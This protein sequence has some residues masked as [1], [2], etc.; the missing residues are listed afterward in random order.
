MPSI[1]PYN[2]RFPVIPLSP[3]D[4]QNLT[5]RNIFYFW[6]PL[7]ATWLMM[8]VEGP[9]LAAV[10]ARLTDPKYNLAAYGV[11][12]S[13]ALIVEA[14]I[15]MIMSASTALVKDRQSYFKL[16]NYT[17]TLN[18]LI[19]AGML[20]GLIPPLFRFVA[21]T[22]I[23]LPKP[24]SELTYGA[25][26]LLIPWPGAIG[27]R[28]FY[29]GVLI[30][31]N[32][33]RLVAVGTVIRLGTMAMTAL[34]LYFMTDIPGAWVGA[35]SLS[36]GVSA[37]ALASKLMAGYNIRK[38][39]LTERADLSP[40]TYRGITV[41]YWPLALTSILSLGVQPMVTF[42]MGHSRYPVESLAVLPVV[43]G[44]VFVFRSMG[45]S[46]QEVGIA[47]MGSNGKGYRPLRRFALI[48][49]SASALG[50]ALVVYTPLNH[51]W[52]HTVSGLSEQLTDFALIPARILV[53]MPALS[54]LISWQRGVLVHGGKTGPISWATAAEVTGIILTLLLATRYLDMVGAT[55]AAIG[56]IIGRLAANTWLTPPVVRIRHRM[57]S[58]LE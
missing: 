43:N 21:E 19:T 44:L 27:F 56:F 36:A 37:E 28:R 26:I 25:S 29:Q 8:S 2:P 17:F 3:V 42:F 47:L 40:L 35:S 20:I 13:F 22:L 33:T 53:L 52:F 16:R 34:L 51:F 48:L 54:V 5:Q 46:F 6:V 10:I 38:L 49:A 45:L 50:L 24:V 4:R 57:R 7:A 15:I 14:P 32:R 23:G 12:F 30:A 58:L 31:G 18:G 11:A 9:F 41:F 1:P 55:A 39:L